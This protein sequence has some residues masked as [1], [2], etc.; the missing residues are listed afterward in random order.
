MQGSRRP[1]RPCAQPQ[2]LVPKRLPA[3]ACSLSTLWLAGLEL[4]ENFPSSFGKIKTETYNRIHGKNQTSVPYCHF[5]S[6]PICCWLPAAD[7][8]QQSAPQFPPYSFCEQDPECGDWAWGLGQGK[9][10]GVHLEGMP[11]TASLC[12]AKGRRSVEGLIRDR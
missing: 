7:L 8:N 9:G 10:Q 6:R 1:P 5:F 2:L 11:A 12:Q 4:N 3:N